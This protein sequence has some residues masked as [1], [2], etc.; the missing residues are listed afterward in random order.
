MTEEGH[1]TPVVSRLVHLTFGL[2]FPFFRWL[3]RTFP[4]EWVAR[5]AAATAERV[6]WAR[7]PVREAILSNVGAAMGLPSTHSRVLAAAGIMVGNHS[8]LWIDLL[9]YAGAPTATVH[10][11]IAA[12][13]GTHWL[14]EARD[15]GKGAILATAHVGNYEIG[16]LLLANLGF[17]LSVVY[18]PD[19]SPVIERHRDASRR[20][21]GVKSIPVTTSPLSFISVLRA[22]EKGEFVAIQGDLDFSGTGRRFPF[23]GREASFPEGLFR[24]AAASGAPIL[25]VFVLRE[26]DGRYRPV[27][28]A[29]IRIAG[30]PSRAAREAA[31]RQ[32]QTAFVTLMEAKIRAYA[33]QW[34]RFTPF[35][36]S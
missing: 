8:R 24:L 33:D 26:P 20:A 10:G 18:A 2:W 6:I 17:E 32:A 9:K 12:H 34:Y 13:E 4:V 7:D 19:P 16:G 15:A 29:P 3:A 36:E 25:P 21:F 30:V 5:L 14:D 35:W 27:V 1:A 11:L 28:E 23:L 22:L 31:V